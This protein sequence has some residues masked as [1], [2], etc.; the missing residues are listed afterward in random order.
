M[1]RQVDHAWCVDTALIA[2]VQP[3]LARRVR[4]IGDPASVG[5]PCG[6]ALLDAGRLRDVADI[7]VFGRY[8]QDV[9]VRFE[10]GS[11]A[12]RR[13]IPVHDLRR[14]VLPV[15]PH[16]C[17]IGRDADVNRM[18]LLGGQIEQVQRIEL[19]VDDRAGTR[20]RRRDVETAALDD[21]A[22]GACADV[23][24]VQR[25][26]TIAIGE[27]VDVVAAGPHRIVVVRVVVRNRHDA[28]VGKVGD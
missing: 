14:D 9:A 6:V 7:A 1:F 8:R 17:H 22:D 20:G 19:R 13:D 4:E 16:R 3:I 10:D 18:F 27:E 26:R 24:A 11:H 23:V 5:R 25:G 21:P 12:G 2:Q 28:R 15:R